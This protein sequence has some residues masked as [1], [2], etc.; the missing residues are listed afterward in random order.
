MTF[1]I[2]ALFRQLSI[3]LSDKE[4]GDDEGQKV[5][6]GERP[7]DAVQAEENRQDDGQEHAEND[8]TG[9]GNDGGGQ[10]LAQRLKVDEG[11]LV[12][13]GQR[14]QAQIGRAHV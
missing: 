5:C 10:R 13:H 12:Q 3:G 9:H 6:C 1:F 7:E 4:E 11:A 8:F 2:A 14:Q